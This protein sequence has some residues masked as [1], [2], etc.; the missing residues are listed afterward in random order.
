MVV[1]PRQE[2]SLF[3]NRDKFDL[4]AVYDGS[5]TSLG[6][7]NSP[8]ATLVRV[9]YE[10]AFRKMLKRMPMML[11]GGISAWKKDLGE[12]EL[13]RGLGYSEIEPPKIERPVP[14]RGGAGSISFASSPNAQQTAFTS[15]SAVTSNSTGNSYE[16]KSPW[17]RPD[18][19]GHHAS[20]SLD[21]SGH[22]RPV[23]SQLY[24]VNT[25]T[26]KTVDHLQTLDMDGYLKMVTNL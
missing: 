22:T 9:I 14:T 10:Q 15:G 13:V 18:G 2:H 23:V 19:M 21:Q 8:L 12:T 3:F 26:L 17:S 20:M 1:G 11:V 6:G 25:D 16:V 5:S 24:C 7:E 4:V